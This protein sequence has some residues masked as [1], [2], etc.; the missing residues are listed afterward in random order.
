M[1]NDLLSKFERFAREKSLVE[2]GDS[3]IVAVS[4]GVDSV[5]LLDLFNRLQKK[6]PLRL[7]IAHVNHQLR[8]NESDRDEEFVWKLGQK[9]GLPVDVERVDTGAYAKQNRLSIQEAARELRYGFLSRISREHRFQKIATAHNAND[10]AETIL[11]NLS[12]GTGL[13]GLSGIPVHRRD[14]NVIRPL[15]FATRAEVEAFANRHRLKYRTDSSN[16]ETEYRRNFIR[17]KIIPLLEK[18]LNPQLVRAIS[19]SSEIFAEL[20]DFLNQE[21]KR[22]LKKVLRFR[23]KEEISLKIHEMKKLHP[24][25]QETI[26]EWAARE[27]QSV[28][29]D[30]EKVSRIAALLHARSGKKVE[31]S[32]SL[33]VY[34]EPECLVFLP[35]P[36]RAHFELKIEPDRSYEIGGA[37]FSSKTLARKAAGSTPSRNIEY[38]DADRLNGRLVLRTW[39]PGDWFVPLGMNG[40]KKLS[41]FFIDEKVPLHQRASIPVLKS[42]GNIVWI[43]GLRL[44]NR[45]RVTPKTR[46]VLRLEF[47]GKVS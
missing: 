8:G 45:Y 43:C 29:L 44:D 5:V 28:P 10:N 32:K 15:L 19:R 34:R 4:G 46:R 12:R 18:S 31:V 17:K 1:A 39:R 25:L 26:I 3:I 22:K 23:S 42:G 30:S 11:L 40:K 36:P 41:D 24:F 21:M 16:R 38:V 33:H 37:R 6:Y 20:G 35:P 47:E 9:Y 2:K 14:L 7:R 27:L 13:Q